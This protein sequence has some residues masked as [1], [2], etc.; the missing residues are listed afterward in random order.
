MITGK[1]GFNP[2]NGR[3]GILISDLWEVEGLHCGKTL[4]YYDYNTDKWI[5]DRL[6][7]E[8]PANNPYLWYLVESNKTGAELE[9]LRVRIK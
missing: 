7:A 3:F 8:Y 6:E 5:S 1:L 9:G 4:E 2:K